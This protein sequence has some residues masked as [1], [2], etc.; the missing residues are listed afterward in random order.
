MTEYEGVVSLCGVLPKIRELSLADTQHYVRP[1]NYMIF[2]M[3]KIWWV[4]SE[5]HFHWLFGSQISF[6]MSVERCDACELS[7]FISFSWESS[8]AFSYEPLET[9]YIPR[10]L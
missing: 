6:K 8:R 9:K 1:H 2:Q 10:E 4:L 7:G 5:I 3:F